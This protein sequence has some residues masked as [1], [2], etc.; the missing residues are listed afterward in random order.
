MFGNIIGKKI[1]CTRFYNDGGEAVPVTVIEA[2]PC[3]VVNV[4]TSERNGYNAVQ[5]GY[6]SKTEKELSKPVSG[7][8]KKLGSD[9]YKYLKEFRVSDLKEVKVNDIVTVEAFKVGEV[10]DVTGTS[11]GKGFQGVVKRH[12][13]KGGPGSHGSMFHRAPGSIGSNTFPG[14]VIKNKKLA[15]RMGNKRVTV[16]HLEVVKLVPEKNIIFIRG[17]VPGSVNSIVDIKKVHA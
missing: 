12:G 3:K 1:G 4:R 13:F 5:L 14:R 2:G 7:Y 9:L 8:Y 16:K 11:K 10:V 17:A 6:C 15:G